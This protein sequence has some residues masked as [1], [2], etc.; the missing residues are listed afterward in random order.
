VTLDAI[1]QATDLY[2]RTADARAIVALVVANLIPLVGVLFFGWSLWTNL[3]IYRLENGIVG[4]WNVPRLLLAG[5]EDPGSANA[6]GGSAVQLVRRALAVGGRAGLAGFFVMHY[7]IFW[8]VH[9]VFILNLPSFAEEV[10]RPDGTLSAALGSGVLT[11][12]APGLDPASIAFGTLDW[13][14]VALAGVALF[15]SHGS[16]FVLNFLAHGEY[17]RSSSSGQM[18]A[19]YARVVA[20]HIAIILGA[21]AVAEAGAPITALVVLVVLKTGF[22]LGLHLVAHISSARERVAARAA[23]GTR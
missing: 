14:A 18:L 12:V 22:D 21:V 10:G 5:A 4:F 11:Q 15:L 6:A 1:G 17:R 20:L 23:S 2:R 8:T 3:V 19:P 13:L 7:G 9:G 16:S